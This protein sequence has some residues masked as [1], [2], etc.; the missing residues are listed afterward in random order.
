MN[1]WNFL[2]VHTARHC[3]SLCHPRAELRWRAPLVVLDID[4]VLD[5]RIVRLSLYDR[6]RHDGAIA[7]ERP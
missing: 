4:G 6:S 2:T 7:A 3:G 1:A 5:R